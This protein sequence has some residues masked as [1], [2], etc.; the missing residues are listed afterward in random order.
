MAR[1]MAIGLTAH[2]AGA[3]GVAVDASGVYVAGDDD[4]TAGLLGDTPAVSSAFLAKFE[5]AAAVVPDSRPHIFPGCV[6]NVAS[7]RGA[8][9]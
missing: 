2:A 7:Y 3:G 4:E 8:E 6:V 5:K 9:A 1:I